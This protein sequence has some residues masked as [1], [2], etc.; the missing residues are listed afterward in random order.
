MIL[1]GGLTIVLYMT[2]LW[3]VSLLVKDSSI[4]DIFWGPGFVV[5]GWLYYALT[6]DGYA[7]RRLLIAALVTLWGLR[8][9]LY[10][11]LRNLPKGE[12]Y[13][14]RN[15]RQQFGGAWWWQSYLRV[16]LLQGAVMWLVSLPLLVGQAGAEPAFATLLDG[17][18]VALWSLGFVF[19]TIGDW[20]LARFK[21][22]PANAGR[23][24]DS[25]L[26]RY[27]RHPNYFGDA[28]VW[29]GLFCIAASAPGGLLTVISPVV[30]TTLLMRVSGVALLER[31]L[32]RTKPEYA[33]YIARTSAFFPRPPRKDAQISE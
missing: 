24:L 10:L 5:V 19:E 27:T 20:Q 9:G 3:L 13:R 29:W 16:F 30:M 32:N 4:V 22:N 12:D 28:V 1:A 25:G 7:P 11:A 31:N 8:L 33:A 18:G 21:A 6:P 15:W 2:V 23:V 26:W 14:Y 17:L